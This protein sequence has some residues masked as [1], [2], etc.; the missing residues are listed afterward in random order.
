[1]SCTLLCYIALLAMQVMQFIDTIFSILPVCPFWT[2]LTETQQNSQDQQL[3]LKN[4]KLL[5][6]EKKLLLHFFFSSKTQITDIE[7]KLDGIFSW[8]YMRDFGISQSNNL[9]IENDFIGAFGCFC[10]LPSCLMILIVFLIIFQARTLLFVFWSQ[11]VLYI[12]S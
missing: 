3:T 5:L 6:L 4:T 10:S 8:L 2:T 1:M 9:S 11:H 7:W 12:I